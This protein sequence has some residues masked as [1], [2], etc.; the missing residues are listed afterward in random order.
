MPPPP[1]QPFGLGRPSSGCR[2][3]LVLLLDLVGVGL[4]AG[5]ELVV[6]VGVQLLEVGQRAQLELRPVG[7]R[8]GHVARGTEG[9]VD[10]LHAPDL[11]VDDLRE[12]LAAD[13]ALHAD[14]PG[15][16]LVPHPHL[17]RNGSSERDDPDH[18]DH[19]DRRKNHLR[20]GGGALKNCDFGLQHHRLFAFF[21]SGLLGISPPSI[22]FNSSIASLANIVVIGCCLKDTCC[23]ELV[24]APLLGWLFVLKP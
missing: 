17:A 14:A 11:R 5:A 10:E 24:I 7:Q 19:R 15:G 9:P 8:N 23:I 6:H 16:D 20:G 21:F 18:S 3:L 12:V 2:L 13:A 1:L 4:C 22:S